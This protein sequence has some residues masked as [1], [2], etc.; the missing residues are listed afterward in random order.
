MANIIESIATGL[1]GLGL[2][3]RGLPSCVNYGIER[4]QDFFALVA[5]YPKNIWLNIAK[6]GYSRLA[7][8]RFTKWKSDMNQ[9]ARFYKEDSLAEPSNKGALG[10]HYEVLA[11]KVEPFIKAIAAIKEDIE[12]A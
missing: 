9:V 12:R 5:L 8:D 3:T 10:P 2:S 1:D 11:G 4:G 7:S 6:D